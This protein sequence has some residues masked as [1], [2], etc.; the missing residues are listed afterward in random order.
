MNH[1]EFNKAVFRLWEIHFA[2]NE[3]IYVPLILPPVVDKGLLF[4]GNNPSFS[5]EGFRR[6][7]KDT[8]LAHIDPH[9]FFHWKNRI[10]LDVSIAI[11]IERFAKDRYPYFNKFRD[12]S[13][14]TSKN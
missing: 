1:Q 6:F 3:D 14:G 7:L 4:I 12:I 11:Q 8:H 5:V 9:E 2:P 13:K 10:K